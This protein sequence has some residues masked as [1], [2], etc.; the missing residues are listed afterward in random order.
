MAAAAIGIVVTAVAI[1]PL[2]YSE[3]EKIC[4]TAAISEI[5]DK[6]DGYGPSQHS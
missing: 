6:L 3:A 5:R 4:Q 1:V 2:D